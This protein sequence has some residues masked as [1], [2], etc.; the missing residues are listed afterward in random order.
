MPG[1]RKHRQRRRDLD[2]P[3][4]ETLQHFLDAVLG[5]GSRTGIRFPTVKLVDYAGREAELTASTNPAAQVVL[6]HLEA[7]ATKGEP[8]SR[9]ARK[10]LLVKSLYDRNWSAAE[11]R[12]LFRLIDWLMELPTELQEG[13]RNDVHQF[14]EEQHMP[15]VTSIERLAKKEGLEEGARTE[16]VEIIRTF[17]ETKFGSAPLPVMAKV[18]SIKELPRLRTL[19]GA[20]IE[21]E[22]LQ[23]FSE[24]L[25]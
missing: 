25:E 24:L 6:A 18:Q 5:W 20:L 23:V 3:W 4:K 21:A 15:Y 10:L 2:S 9:R 16:L 8:E 7:R 19:H 13:F 14:E 1:K 22:S 17:L 12:Q 11:V